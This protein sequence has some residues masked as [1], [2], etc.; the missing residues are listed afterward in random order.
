MVI[1]SLK[2]HWLRTFIIVGMFVGA[3]MV[4]TLIEAEL[5]PIAQL[6]S[7]LT[8]FYDINDEGRSELN[9]SKF[10][11][12]IKNLAY[13]EAASSESQTVLTLSLTF[14]NTLSANGQQLA[15]YD[16]LIPQLDFSIYY[17][18]GRPYEN[19]YFI[20][21]DFKNSSTFEDFP[22]P[23]YDF[24]AWVKVLTIE[25]PQEYRIQPGETADVTVKIT[26]LSNGE[27]KN[28]LSQF[29]GSFIRSDMPDGSM[30]V[31][32]NIYMLG[33]PIPIDLAVPS[34]SGV[35]GGL[36]EL[37][38]M[39][40]DVV[41]AL[42]VTGPTGSFFH[43]AD[44]QNY[45]DLNGN[46]YRD[47]NDTYFAGIPEF[48]SYSGN[49][50]KDKGEPWIEPLLQNGVFTVDLFLQLQEYLQID[51]FQVTIPASEWDIEVAQNF[52][53]PHYQIPA[54]RNRDLDTLWGTYKQ[55]LLLY[56]PSS[57][58]EYYKQSNWSNRIIGSIGF[59]YN[60]T[61]N[62]DRT[63][64]T[65][66]GGGRDD[67]LPLDLG[68]SIKLCGDARPNANF[69]PGDAI[70][71]FTPLV[72]S[73]LSGANNT[74]ILG[75]C[76]N[77]EVI[78]G[79]MP[80]SLTLDIQLNETIDM[81]EE[82]A[83]GQDEG[84]LSII[85][86]I[87]GMIGNMINI[88][89]FAFNGLAMDVFSKVL[90]TNETLNL[91]LFFPYGLYLPETE[92][93]ATNFIQ[94]TGGPIQIFNDSIPTGFDNWTN[95]QKN[96]WYEDHLLI[97][98]SIESQTIQDSLI[99]VLTQI[100]TYQNG[101]GIA[102]LWNTP[103]RNA[104]ILNESN[105]GTSLPALREG[106]FPV[107]EEMKE[108]Q[109]TL[110]LT[111]DQLRLDLKDLLPE[112]GPALDSMISNLGINTNLIDYLEKGLDDWG[113]RT[114]LGSGVNNTGTL[115]DILSFNLPMF[116][117]LL[118]QDGP[119]NDIFDYINDYNLLNE[120]YSALNMTALI[121]GILGLLGED[122][123]SNIGGS[124]GGEEG[125]LDIISMLPELLQATGINFQE[126]LPELIWW[127]QNNLSY[128]QGLELFE[129]LD[130]LMS[131]MGT[132][133][134]GSASGG[135]M[136]LVGGLLGG[137]TED[138]WYLLFEQVKSLLQTID[139]M[140]LMNV[141]SGDLIPYIDYM[142]RSQLFTES[143]LG[144]LVSGLPLDVAD[145]DINKV[146]RNINDLYSGLVYGFDI[147]LYDYSW[148]NHGIN[149][150]AM[151]S[152]GEMIQS[153]DYQGVDLFEEYAKETMESYYNYANGIEVYQSGGN[154]WI[155]DTP[156]Y[157]NLRLMSDLSFALQ[158]SGID[159]E[160]VWA[161]LM[162]VLGFEL[163]KGWTESGDA[164]ALLGDLGDILTIA[165]AMSPPGEWISFLRELGIWSNWE[166]EMPLELI[167]TVLGMIDIPLSLGDLLGPLVNLEK[168]LATGQLEL[169][170][171]LLGL[172]GM[173][174]LIF[175]VPLS[176]QEIWGYGNPFMYEAGY[177]SS[178]N[179]GPYHES[180]DIW[181]ADPATGE[182][183]SND[184]WGWVPAGW[185]PGGLI[186]GNPNRNWSS[187]TG[188]D[189]PRGFMQNMIAN[190]PLAVD[191]DIAS[192]TIPEMELI[193]LGIIAV[194]L[195][196][197]T[198]P[199]DLQIRL[200][201]EGNLQN[202]VEVFE[203]YG[204]PLI[205]FGDHMYDGNLDIE[206]LEMLNPTT[207][208]P[209]GE[210]TWLDMIPFEDIDIGNILEAALDTGVQ[211][212]HIL[213]YMLD[214]EFMPG[215][216]FFLDGSHVTWDF[217]IEYPVGSGNYIEVDNPTPYNLFWETDYTDDAVW[218]STPYPDAAQDI[219]QPP[220][221]PDQVHFCFG[222]GD[223]IPDEYPW[224]R[225]VLPS[226]N[227][228]DPH[229][230]PGLYDAPETVRN[231]PI[232]DYLTP[233]GFPGQGRWILEP[234]GIPDGIQHY[235]YDTPFAYVNTTPGADLP[236]SNIPPDYW[237]NEN[238][239]GADNGAWEWDIMLNPGVGL[240]Y[241]WTLN[242]GESYHYWG[243]N[244]PSEYYEYR[245]MFPVQQF[246]LI[247]LPDTY[248]DN[249][250]IGDGIS[251]PDLYLSYDSYS[252]Q[253]NTGTAPVH[254]SI[255]DINYEYP[256]IWDGFTYACHKEDYRM[257]YW[258]SVID[259]IT[260]ES[261]NVLNTDQFWKW[262][263][264][265]VTPHLPGLL[266]FLDLS[267]SIGDLVG[268]LTSGLGVGSS[269]LG[270]DYWH[271]IRY[272]ESYRYFEPGWK[273]LE[274]RGF[275]YISNVTGGESNNTDIYGFKGISIIN[276]A[277]TA[278]NEQNLPV[279]TTY[280]NGSF[281]I[282]DNSSYFGNSYQTDLNPLGL[283]QWIWD[284]ASDVFNMEYNTTY[285]N[286][287]DGKY[288]MPYST[289]N[290]TGALN[291]L[292]DQGLSIDF[293]L[294]SLPSILS[295]FMAEG[296]SGSTG[297]SDLT[298]IIDLNSIPNIFNALERYF[299]L[300]V[301]GN[302]ETGTF[303]KTR[304]YEIMLQMISQI[305]DVLD[306][307][308]NKALAGALS[309]LM[310]RLKS[311]IDLDSI[312]GSSGGVSGEGLTE[313]MSTLIT[314]LKDS[315]FVDIIFSD[316]DKLKNFAMNITLA[317][318]KFNLTLFGMK[319]LNIDLSLS[320][321]LDLSSV[322]GGFLGESG[323]EEGGIA[324]LPLTM[325][326]I[327]LEEI[328]YIEISTF[329]GP[330]EIIFQAINTTGSTVSSIP[331]AELSYGTIN[332]WE[333]P[334]N[335]ANNSYYLNIT[336]Y[337]APQ[338]IIGYTYDSNNLPIRYVVNGSYE[339][340]HTNSTGYITINGTIAQDGFGWVDPYIYIH[341]EPVEPD[342]LQPK[343]YWWNV[344]GKPDQ[345]TLR[346]NQ[347]LYAAKWVV[348]KAEIGLTG[349]YLRDMTI[350]DY[351]PLPALVANID[352]DS[353]TEIFAR[354][355][356]DDNKM[357]FVHQ[358]HYMQNGSIANL[359]VSHGNSYDVY[360]EDSSIIQ[361]FSYE[362]KQPSVKST[363]Y[364][365][366]QLVSPDGSNVVYPINS[367]IIT[368][369]T[370]DS[371]NWVDDSLTKAIIYYYD[372]N[373]TSFANPIYLLDWDIRNIGSWDGGSKRTDGNYF[374][375]SIDEI[376]DNGTTL[377]EYL[378]Q[379][380]PIT[381][382]YDKLKFTY[383]RSVAADERI[384]SLDIGIQ[385]FN[386]LTIEQV[387][388]TFDV[389]DKPGTGTT[390]YT[391]FD[392]KGYT[393]IPSNNY[394]IMQDRS[395]NPYIYG[396]N[397]SNPND[398]PDPDNDQ[399]CPIQS[400]AQAD[401]TDYGAHYAML[402]FTYP[403]PQNRYI[404]GVWW[405][406]TNFDG[407]SGGNG[408]NTS[409]YGIYIDTFKAR[410]Y[411]ITDEQYYWIAIDPSLLTNPDTTDSGQHV[412]ECTSQPVGF[413]NDTRP[414]GNH[415]LYLS[416][417]Q[418]TIEEYWD[419]IMICLIVRDGDYATGGNIGYN[420][421]LGTS[422]ER[423]AVDVY[424]DLRVNF[425]TYDFNQWGLSK[426]ELPEGLISGFDVEMI[427]YDPLATN[428]TNP[429]SINND[430][431][432]VIINYSV[433][434]IEEGDG[435]SW[436]TDVEI[437]ASKAYILLQAEDSVV[438][439]ST[440]SGDFLFEDRNTSNG[441]LPIPLDAQY[442]PYVT[443]N[444]SILDI[445]TQYT[446]SVNISQDQALRDYWLNLTNIDTDN[447]DYLKKIERLTVNC[448]QNPEVT[449]QLTAFPK[450]PIRVGN[451]THPE[452]F[453]LG[454]E[455]DLDPWTGIVAEYE[456]IYYLTLRISTEMIKA[457]DAAGRD[458]SVYITFEASAVWS[459]PIGSYQVEQNT[460][461]FGISEGPS[462]R[463]IYITH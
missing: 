329:N 262:L 206:L 136:G 137:I 224:Y 299:S 154:Y 151:L 111:I 105:R 422:G 148:E 64:L 78:L 449:R 79:K 409:S 265:S 432:W 421:T 196:D 358:I 5:M 202:F 233:N 294:D 152:A 286:A 424:I 94:L 63:Y 400:G 431:S 243:E 191:V 168:L 96:Q 149:L 95:T 327:E 353:N 430:F 125:G 271:Q 406:I 369:I 357:D 417:R 174:P 280:P 211:I 347:P 190:V 437:L 410:F 29:L 308:P 273:Y 217:W 261:H 248:W 443:A 38:A 109:Y 90:Q 323:S 335:P 228:I 138:Q 98:M 131:A 244:T 134:G 454:R 428:Q 257:G 311:L 270:V 356:I 235:W 37:T 68:A 114:G 423:N 69:G 450:H 14:E 279:W 161:I 396:Y 373:D 158:Q 10:L 124:I 253:P 351:P 338:S 272:N 129:M 122:A 53:D 171:E 408:N 178:Y 22:S 399:R 264:Y 67:F 250:N 147:P 238:T 291:W 295:S 218:A 70:N 298:S 368:K 35:G 123:L 354:V 52:S 50:K 110:E 331:D 367:K 184:N 306:I 201:L 310:P 263:S 330:F 28:A 107:G 459:K 415:S 15:Y 100:G 269:S 173:D 355:E 46:H 455:I 227:Q 167:I 444:I 252:G 162:D 236:W 176:T 318:T 397:Q 72:P 377:W 427:M 179:T 232:I 297:I 77:M 71:V 316:T 341:A 317:N 177:D 391:I 390:T 321:D 376:A 284:G 203:D 245:A 199:L 55:Q 237:N 292:Y 33:I 361:N 66:P 207:P 300:V 200:R 25:I 113:N 195:A 34:L 73:L 259:P 364:E 312:L 350:Q 4:P 143:V 382:R 12:N 320:L 281:F 328:P 204:I 332:Y 219:N 260:G 366:V 88:T 31:K 456:I 144:P 223:G 393:T 62:F 285:W 371:D 80:L 30:H 249:S 126:M 61:M 268:S 442:R 74:I 65:Q 307:N 84:A 448:L 85:P 119:Q 222:D 150:F 60:Q 189:Y 36:S 240:Y 1:D 256:D 115:A 457:W 213:Q 212:Q 395:G 339:E 215:H 414:Y 17:K 89:S 418:S 398:P 197:T 141:V 419:Y 21:S 462:T 302:A 309:Y 445:E 145:L 165:G 434:D 411:N 39:L 16:M 32:G 362:V 378:S 49:G 383:S 288:L 352:A 447:L 324:G 208:T 82:G 374:N 275:E 99:K 379:S 334:E 216:R 388:V 429:G 6:T 290:L 128:Q 153:V 246:P 40:L 3:G 392:E 8:Q 42:F 24:Y 385:N 75:I 315:G 103:D 130:V 258:E 463:R 348:P 403:I 301:G 405:N 26:L 23:S 163:T 54:T 267:S 44:I 296:S 229:Q 188:K 343:Y 157:D 180:Q 363:T 440:C 156:T 314:M 58:A 182:S 435:L 239:A 349:M 365:F 336:V 225:F 381:E 118:Y 305:P 112:F 313:M 170:P 231:P 458:N 120:S 7:V 181:Y 375:L 87:M 76:G 127:L 205:G 278:I 402:N 56:M 438:L 346:G 11:P 81:P 106:T 384:H 452:T 230:G 139:M 439:A 194:S 13:D 289:P 220:G 193:D 140:D 426:V 51:N 97:N 183:S 214:P 325:P 146:L 187:L 226:A 345:K 121:T 372:I 57:G 48:A 404:S 254:S 83:T 142:N 242:N 93:E 389:N 322:I 436:P 386:S 172:I 198:I 132:G 412:Y 303:N 413:H 359:N 108:E 407:G 45:K 460:Y 420:D 394:R 164:T 453:Q 446:I 360:L 276:G 234:D 41:N 92:E 27:A 255:S 9:I 340:T 370:C 104:K 461:L 166:G 425:T 133:D 175:E 441:Y 283:L 387:K 20:L 433:S 101:W 293:I 186:Y 19:E 319:F 86:D 135:T 192:M 282:W 221:H 47:W 159:A 247:D 160:I 241:R 401:K 266:D 251:Y 326:S 169:L 344:T 342:P 333:D 209:A 337:N 210:G 59:L 91:D 287:V 416:N 185:D 155:A 2:K 117:S 274:N 102:Y 18:A 43:L 451:E 304:G 277:L 116:L 380:S